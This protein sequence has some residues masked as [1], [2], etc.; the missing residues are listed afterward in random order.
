MKLRA[1][2][3]MDEAVAHF[4]VS[5]KGPGMYHADLVRYDGQ[6]GHEPPSRI[7]LIRGVRQWTGSC[8]NEALLDR[9]GRE[10]D[11]AVTEAP[12]FRENRHKR[13]RG[14]SPEQKENR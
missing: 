9:I 5:H 2:V 14:G 4:A 6:P 12:I 8:D 13:N 7:L 11:R 3:K 1:V 10:I